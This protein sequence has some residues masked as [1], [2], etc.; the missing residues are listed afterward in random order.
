MEPYESIIPNAQ[1]MNQRQQNIFYS[2][3]KSIYSDNNYN[4]FD[5]DLNE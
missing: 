2:P 1:Y 5:Q 4:T 3:I